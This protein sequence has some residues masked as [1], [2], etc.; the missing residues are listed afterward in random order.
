[1][2]PR[3]HTSTQVTHR[4][5]LRRWLPL[6]LQL[7]RILSSLHTQTASP[8]ASTWSSSVHKKYS[9]MNKASNKCILHI[10]IYES[11]HTQTL[12][13]NFQA[14]VLWRRTIT[15]HSFQILKVW[16]Q[17]VSLPKQKG[18]KNRLQNLPSSQKTKTKHLNL[19]QM[20][21]YPYGDRKSR[22]N[23]IVPGPWVTKKALFPKRL[24]A[25]MFILKL[26]P[27]PGK[28]GRTPRS[29]PLPSWSELLPSWWSL[30]EVSGAM[31]D[32]AC[33]SCPSLAL[34]CLLLWEKP[35]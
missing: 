4:C 8:R 34:L 13:E 20:W 33:L 19:R 2:K 17:I 32:T 16:G 28:A 10:W 22:R 3:R 24:K 25:T 26:F 9:F 27:S 35:V 23:I 1:M 21:G 12:K 6:Q 18:Y 11:A 31:G 5:F 30:Q 15:I 14:S 7:T 29:W